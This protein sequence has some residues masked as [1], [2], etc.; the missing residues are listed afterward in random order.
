MVYDAG[1]PGYQKA[2][3]AQAILAKM[4]QAAQGM[5][6]IDELL[7]WLAHTF[8]HQFDVQAAQFWSPQAKTRGLT[9]LRMLVCK[10][11]SLPYTSIVNPQIIAVAEAYMQAQKSLKLQLV[12]R[13]LPPDN[14]KLL[15]QYQLN[16]C[17][18]FFMSDNTF[19]PPPMTQQKQQIPVPMALLLLLFFSIPS[20]HLPV[21]NHIL[22]QIVPI[23]RNCG[24]L[25]LSPH[26]TASPAKQQQSKTLS[27]AELIPKQVEDP[28]DNPFGSTV[29]IPDKQARRL[30]EAIDGRRNVS[31]LCTITRLSEQD[32]HIAL[33]KLL[34]LHHIHVY[35]P[36]GKCVDAAI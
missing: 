24:L 35:E 9:E 32:V 34:R 6:H 5:Q 15:S 7:L 13:L 20:P 29:S 2:D 18:G 27:L 31:Q 23:A 16:Y 21:I 3:Q 1:A 36:G 22:A 33:Q 19:L 12:Y 14:A 26:T 8:I 25:L 10:D 17:S 30:Y 11:T 4:V 28:M